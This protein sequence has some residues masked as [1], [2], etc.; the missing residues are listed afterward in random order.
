MH[1]I[2]YIVA[3][4]QSGNTRLMG[5]FDMNMRVYH[6]DLFDL[7][8]ELVYDKTQSGCSIYGESATNHFDGMGR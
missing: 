1:P 4:S 5:F 7:D 3:D 8:G 2:K 6:G